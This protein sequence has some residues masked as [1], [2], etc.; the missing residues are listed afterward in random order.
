MPK[1]AP[2]LAEQGINRI[3]QNTHRVIAEN[4]IT[5]ESKILA[6][7]DEE[8]CDQAFENQLEE[9]KHKRLKLNPGDRIYIA[10]IYLGRVEFGPDFSYQLFG[11]E[12]K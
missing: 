7:G 1:V 2:K 12:L 11:K 8:F 3:G 5:G 6:F 10:E 4:V 9:I